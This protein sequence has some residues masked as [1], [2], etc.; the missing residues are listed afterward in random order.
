MSQAFRFPRDLFPR[1]LEQ[2][3]TRRALLASAALAAVLAPF[4]ARGAQE[5]EIEEFDASGKS[6]GVKRVARIVKTDAE[7]R[8]QLSPIAYD[9]TRREGTERAFTGAYFDK[10]DNG[11]YRCVCCDTALFDS[12]T[13]YESGTGWPSYFAPISKANVVET[14]DTSFGMRRVAVSCRRCDAHLGHVFTD[15]PKPT[16]LRYCMNSAALTFAPRAAA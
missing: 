11:L 15:G 12:A 6:R 5:V 1:V 13:K 8:A 9:V 3:P 2:R 10:H 14:A 7:W 16:G 4:A